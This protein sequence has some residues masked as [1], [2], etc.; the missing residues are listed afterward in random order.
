MADG[1][2]GLNK[3]GGFKE[4]SASLA[5]IPTGPFIAAVRTSPLNESIGQ[6][7][8]ALSAV[9]KLGFL[10]KDVSIPVDFEAEVLHELLMSR[11]FGSGIVVEGYSASLEEICNHLMVLIGEL[12]G[13]DPESHGFYFDR[14]SVLI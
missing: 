3:L 9:R 8:V 10:S 11:T 13:G 6:E 1:A 2:V 12:L 5:L 14:G 4:S 7:A